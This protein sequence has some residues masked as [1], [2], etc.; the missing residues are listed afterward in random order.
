M[1]Q[2]TIDAAI[3]VVIQ[4]LEG[5]GYRKLRI[6]ETDVTYQALS[7]GRCQLTGRTRS[8]KRY[9]G[10]HVEVG[11]C[12]PEGREFTLWLKEKDVGRFPLEATDV[13]E[14]E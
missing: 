1:P 11:L 10:K 2:T 7:D 14:A 13:E 6:P 4:H 5:D 3:R 8:W 9:G 12:S